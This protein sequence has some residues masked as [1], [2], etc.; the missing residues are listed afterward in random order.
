MKTNH[1]KK[2]T[3]DYG[4]IERLK[5]LRDLLGNGE[6]T[7][8]EIFNA[9]PQHYQSTPSDNRR[10]SRDINALRQLGYSVVT[11][12]LKYTYS[13]ITKSTLILEDSDVRT[14]SLIQNTFAS[15]PPIAIDVV[16]V[17]DRIFNALP[18]RQYP[19]IAK[20]PAISILLKPAVDYIPFI[21]TVQL[22]EK[23]I[24]KERKV[25]FIY[26]SLNGVVGIKHIGVEPYEIQFFDNHFYLIGVTPQAIQMMEF[27]IDR[28]RELVIMPGK[29]TRSRK[30][31]T[32][33]FT[34]KLSK[35]IADQGI[36]ERFLNQKVEIQDDGSAIVLAE[37]YS[38]FRIIQG[39]LR[40]GEQAEILTPISL[41]KNMQ[42]V[43][44]SMEKLYGR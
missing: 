19:L 14:L 28:I 38:E 24:Q 22:L 10:L 42:R 1:R 40:Y 21:G 30:R 12:R 13:I 16:P 20:Q 7:K 39:I 25:Q 33:S 2:E 4:L 36:S 31:S 11:N 23:A 8:Q 43:I 44:K 37:G 17:L 29:S 35:K 34:Y 6:F 41:R 32:I 18:E 26:P 27:R 3:G 5:M 15:N 9:L